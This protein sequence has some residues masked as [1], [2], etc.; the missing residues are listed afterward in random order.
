MATG[1]SAD[2]LTI[3][4]NGVNPGGNGEAWIAEIPFLPLCSLLEDFDDG[5]TAEWW[6]VFQLD[7]SDAPWIVLAPDAATV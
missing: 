1:V 6:E 5:L 7:A 4:G 2:G 3:V